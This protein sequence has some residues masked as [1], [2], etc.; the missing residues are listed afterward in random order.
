M[1]AARPGAEH[2]AAID[3]RLETD[4]EE[5]PM[6]V[7]ILAAAAGLMLLQSTFGFAAGQSGANNTNDCAAGTSNTTKT[8]D[9][10]LEQKKQPP[11]ASQSQ[12]QSP[13]PGATGNA[14]A[15]QPSPTTG[16]STSN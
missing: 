10:A 6:N 2:S 12:N 13:P 9:C 4:R 8:E 16:G 1:A 3:I 11:G 7:R 15:I 14:G 5:C